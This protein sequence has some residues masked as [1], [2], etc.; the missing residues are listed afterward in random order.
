MPKNGKILFREKILKEYFENIYLIHNSFLTK[1]QSFKFNEKK[2]FNIFAYYFF[3][4]E[5]SLMIWETFKQL[6]IK[7]K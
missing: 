6:L 2:Y 1:N 3:V 7:K 5:L 4:I